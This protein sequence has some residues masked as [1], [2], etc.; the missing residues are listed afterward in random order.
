M[1]TYPDFNELLSLF[2]SFEARYLIV[3]GYALMRY[4]E[5][6]FTK[7]LD[8]V[9]AVDED[10]AA[11]VFEALRTFGAPLEDLTAKDFAVEGFYYQMGHPPVRVDVFMSI[12][13]VDFEEAWERRET[14]EIA[15]TPMHF[16]SKEDLIAAK[17]AAGR[18]QDLVDV[19]NLRR[20]DA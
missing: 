8:V 16:I 18:P 12:P 2:A 14:V 19:E 3:G 1:L 11:A 13:G 7:D 10:N 4:A 6:R 15:G 17:L 5:P 9:I 20:S